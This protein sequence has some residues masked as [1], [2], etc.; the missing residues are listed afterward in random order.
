MNTNKN[1]SQEDAKNQENT[2]IQNILNNRKTKAVKE[3]EQPELPEVFTSK[4]F[5]TDNNP[6]G[7]MKM[8]TFKM[9]TNVM[10]ESELYELGDSI[11]EAQR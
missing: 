10:S 4:D 3:V 6:F 1:A 11:G 9:L 8:E 2:L 5:F 7:L